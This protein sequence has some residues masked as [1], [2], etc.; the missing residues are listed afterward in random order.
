MLSSEVVEDE[1]EAAKRH[2]KAKENRE[3][4]RIDNMLMDGIQNITLSKEMNKKLIKR[5]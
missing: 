4:D 2:E 5:Q 3:L 1:D